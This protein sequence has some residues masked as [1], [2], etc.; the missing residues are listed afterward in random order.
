MYACMY[1][2]MHV[3]MY[4]YV[5]VFLQLFQKGKTTGRMAQDHGDDG[6]PVFSPRAAEGIA[7]S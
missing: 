6:G 4:L 3:R 2:C 1:V 5:H 7:L